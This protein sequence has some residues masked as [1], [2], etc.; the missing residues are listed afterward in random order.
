[1]HV[2][3][4]NR[5]GPEFFQAVQAGRIVLALRHRLDPGRFCGQIADARAGE[6]G[7][8]SH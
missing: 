6:K 4:A 3:K 2:L 8:M 1:M 5:F 7:E